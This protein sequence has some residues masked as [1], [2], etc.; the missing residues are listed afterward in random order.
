MYIFVSYRLRA[1]IEEKV[2]HKLEREV[3]F[4]FGMKQGHEYIM[5]FTAVFLLFLMF[6]ALR[7]NTIRC[8]VIVNIFFGIQFF[9]VVLDE[10]KN[11]FLMKLKKAYSHSEF[12]FACKLL[13]CHINYF[14]SWSSE[15]T[16]KNLTVNKI[17]SKNG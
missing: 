11:A 15:T 8:W 1:N 12:K 17:Y 5:Y 14:V 13:T 3:G 7:T 6:R 4:Y 16:V 10:K 9:L 2:S